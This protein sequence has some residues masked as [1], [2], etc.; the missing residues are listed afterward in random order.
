MGAN[1][2][3]FENLWSQPETPAVELLSRVSGRFYEVV[4]SQWEVELPQYS[5]SIDVFE[6][7]LKHCKR[8]MEKQ[9]SDI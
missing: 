6:R 1:R 8:N 4:D 3:Q 7:N 2:L 9:H 5:Q